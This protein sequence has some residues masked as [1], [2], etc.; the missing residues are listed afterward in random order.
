MGGVGVTAPLAR[1][2][3]VIEHGQPIPANVRVLRDK[4]NDLW[5]PQRGGWILTRDD[6]TATTERERADAEPATE[7]HLLMFWAPLTVVEVDPEP[8]PAER[9]PHGER[10][11]CSNGGEHRPHYWDG[12]TDGRWCPGLALDPEPD[13]VEAPAIEDDFAMIAWQLGRLEAGHP[14]A[15]KRK[16][17]DA[18]NRIAERI[19]RPD[20]GPLVLS[21][22]QVPDGTVA[23]I[24]HQ[25][26]RRVSIPGV[27]LPCWQSD[28]TGPLDL[29][30]ML[31]AEPD[32][33]TV[34]FAP[35]PEP[36]TWPAIDPM[37]E[38]DDL[39]IALDVKLR[40]PLTGLQRWTL[41]TDDGL[42][43]GPLGGRRTLAELRCLGDVTE[44]LPS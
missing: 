31:D 28:L 43:T 6:G 8:Q 24:G 14:E 9:H 39:P 25:R 18:L 13:P 4:V 10:A 15:S 36:R 23:L 5:E 22:P 40:E 7:A 19:E 26:W 11:E 29:G 35:P 42:Y 44:V 21:L 30:A 12:R 33:V 38:G 32:G 20:P 37:P 34:E 27:T 1:V 17:M 16:A 2:G 3:D 41:V